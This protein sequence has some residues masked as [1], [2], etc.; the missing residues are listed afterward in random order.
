MHIS[1]VTVALNA[2]DD[3]PVTIESVLAQDHPDVEFIVVDGGSWDDTPE[4]LARYE[5][6]IDAIHVIDDGGIYF[7]MNQATELASGDFVLFLNAGDRFHQ[8]NTLRRLASRW[9]GRSDV[10]YGNHIYVDRG[11]EAFQAATEFGL[12]RTALRKGRPT[13]DMMA[14]FPAH[15][16]TVTRTSLLRAMRYD[17]AFRICADHDFLLR[18][19]SN[20]VRMQYV[21]EIV[22][23]YMGGGMSS[24]RNALCRLEWNALYR[25][26]SEKPDQIDNYFY[27]EGSP[28][29]GTSSPMAG[30]PLGGLLPWS[31]PKPEH[32]IPEPFRWASAQGFRIVTPNYSAT[33]AVVLDGY[34]LVPDQTVNVYV[35]DEL[36]Q[37]TPMRPGA[38]NLE[39]PFDPPLQARTVIEI[40]PQEADRPDGVPDV[41][42]LAVTDVSFTSANT[43]APEPRRRGAT[44]V[45]NTMNAK[46]N[47]DLMGTGWWDPEEHH[48]WSAGE[49]SELRVASYDLLEQITL[50]VRANPLTREQT[51]KVTL[52]GELVLETRLHGGAERQEVVVPVRKHFRNDGSLN[53]LRLQPSPVRKP[54][55]DPRTL[56]V[57]LFSMTLG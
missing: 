36:F 41:V 31:E 3:L 52:N 33:A 17:T 53:R 5:G 1:V 37:S 21:D 55:S 19:A 6:D 49:L 26:F 35:R 50:Q 28:F 25:A 45:F 18:A 2:A 7:A 32:G 29:A 10:V 47:A 23:L 27:S 13:P 11:V 51:L 54:P 34:N 12:I 30:G 9:D 57:A 15:Q 42:S 44:I 39:I 46:A 48:Q 8:A 24:K 16:A 40:A 43:E 56:G 20:G 38:F 4:V 14:Q 22:A